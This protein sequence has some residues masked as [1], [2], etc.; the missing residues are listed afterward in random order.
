MDLARFYLYLKAVDAVVNLRYPS[1]GESSGTLARA[2]AEGR[3]MIVNNLGSF[4]EIPDDVA[5]KVEVDGDQAAQVAEHLF[6]LADDHAMRAAMEERARAYAR[7]VL[8]PR[9]CAALYVRLAEE[10]AAAINERA[11]SQVS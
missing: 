11:S 2:L 5:L 7:T 10:T 3:A 1:A 8:D 6:G 9:R 4:A